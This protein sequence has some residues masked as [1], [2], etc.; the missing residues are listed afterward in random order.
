MNHELKSDDWQK[1]FEASNNLRRLL[2]FHCSYLVN[3]AMFN[4]HSTTQDILRMV[5]SLRS[6]LAKNGLIT[7]T[8]MC[9]VLKKQMDS[10]ADMIFAKLIK[11]GSDANSFI[12][13]EVKRALIAVSQNCSD[14]KI[15]PI[16]LSMFQQKA[17]PAKINIALCCEAV[18]TKNENR[19]N[20]LRDFDKI[21]IILGNY[22]LDSANEVRN[23]S[24]QA[25][26]TLVSF[27]FSKSELDKILQRQFTEANLNR[28]NTII[29]K[30]LSQGNSTLMITNLQGILLA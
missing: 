26:S 9:G 10:E 19:V 25:M 6:N 21:V 1:Q 5:E 18:I 13:E 28:I 29:S 16:L 22:I 11:K 8:E 17:I 24:K 23:A 3:S 12:S 7:L 4:L 14:T 15:I 30:E 2:Q 27:L 20:Q